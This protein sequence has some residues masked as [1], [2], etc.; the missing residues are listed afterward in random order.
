L[1]GTDQADVV[2]HAICEWIIGTILISQREEMRT[3]SDFIQE[4][5]FTTCLNGFIFT[6]SFSHRKEEGSKK[7]MADVVVPGIMYDIIRY[8]KLPAFGGWNFGWYFW[9]CKRLAGT[10]F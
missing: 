9:N 8:R 10:Q 2:L 6:L 3:F 1:S 7:C 4:C 5:F